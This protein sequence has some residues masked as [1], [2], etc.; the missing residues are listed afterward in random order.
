M[1]P[2][3]EPKPGT[4]AIAMWRHDDDG[5][6]WDIYQLPHP[7]LEGWAVR[8]GDGTIYPPDPKVEPELPGPCDYD[9]LNTLPGEI[10]KASVTL[11]TY[12]RKK[13][14]KRWKLFGIQ[15]REGGPR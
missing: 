1:T 2:P 4:L 8:K 3:P 7:L 6:G 15:E 10:I 12:F 9:L 5:R 13:G 14:I 11:E